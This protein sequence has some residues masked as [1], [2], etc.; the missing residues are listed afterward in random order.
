MNLGST[1]DRACSEICNGGASWTCRLLLILAAV[2]SFCA[3][4]R[5][6]ISDCV[7]TDNKG[8]SSGEFVPEFACTAARH[9]SARPKSSKALY[10]VMCFPT[11][12][13]QTVSS[14]RIPEFLLRSLLP[15]AC[16]E[17]NM[18]RTCSKPDFVYYLFFRKFGFLK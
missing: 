8:N 16:I 18:V 13:L 1:C 10:Q 6:R 11:C 2:I 17:I 12:I 15:I 14:G 7:D 9:V 3:L 4:E 5:G